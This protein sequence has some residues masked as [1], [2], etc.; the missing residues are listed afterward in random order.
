MGWPAKLGQP[1]FR[2]VKW[3]TGFVDFDNDGWVDVFVANGHVYPQVDAIPGSPGYK[4]PMQIFRNHHDGSFEDISKASGVFDMP[5]ESR[6]GAAFGDV[7]NDGNMDILVLNIGQPPS[8]LINKAANSN[9]RVAFHLI[10]TKSNR[11]AIG[12]RV[13]IHAAGVM[14][15]NEV[16]G[17]GG[18]LSQNDLRLHFGLEVADK[19]ERVEVSWPSGQTELIRDVAADFIYTITESQGITG[20]IPLPPPL[21]PNTPASATTAN[22]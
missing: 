14:Q 9:H 7:Y 16:R 15:F 18:Y 20:R 5:L 13:T 21:K 19:M 22:R 4:E 1:S 11:A 17:G 2:Y 3:G 6:R 10:G 12:A 8:L